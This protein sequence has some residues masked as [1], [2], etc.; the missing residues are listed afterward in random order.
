MSL[1]KGTADTFCETRVERKKLASG[2][3]IVPACVRI[4]SPD[5]TSKSVIPSSLCEGY[6]LDLPW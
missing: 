5:K 6:G 3:Q 4:C 1:G 2:V